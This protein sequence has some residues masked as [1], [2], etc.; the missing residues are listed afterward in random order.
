[1]MLQWVPYQRTYNFSSILFY[2]LIVII[3]ASQ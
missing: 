2:E 3:M 1:M